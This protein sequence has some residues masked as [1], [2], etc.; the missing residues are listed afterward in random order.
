MRRQTS[1]VPASARQPPNVYPFRTR[2]A[3]KAR[4]LRQHYMTIC[5]GFILKPS[6]GLEPST[7]SLPWKSRGGTGGHA[8]VI[9]STFVA[10]I[11]CWRCVGSARV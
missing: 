11:A 7:P 5:R 10:Q 2:K 1:P 9:V 4:Q 8:W 3:V 6:D